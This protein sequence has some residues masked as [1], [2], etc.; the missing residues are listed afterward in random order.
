M[1]NGPWP[2]SE[3][4]EGFCLPIPARLVAGG[5][6]GGAGEPQGAKRYLLVGL[7]RGGGG[8]KRFVDVRQRGGT[9]EL[10]GEGLWWKIGDEGRP[11]SC[12]RARWSWGWGLC[13][14]SGRGGAG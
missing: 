12:V 3:Q 13:G 8:R 4:R 14:R 5:E 1:Q 10:D 2:E 11:V 7:G 9:K 6:G